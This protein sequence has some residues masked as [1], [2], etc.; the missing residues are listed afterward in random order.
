M[1]EWILAQ[2]HN[3][4]RPLEAFRRNIASPTDILCEF[5]EGANWEDI[6]EV[7]CL[8]ANIVYNPYRGI[9]PGPERLLR[10]QCSLITY[11][12]FVLPVLA[13]A[14]DPTLAEGLEYCALVCC[15]DY[16][17]VAARRVGI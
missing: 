17:S 12:A 3:L 7:M 14:R 1:K 6:G 13:A 16:P 9:W 8:S 15:L 2:T 5:V 10:F 4:H 11:I